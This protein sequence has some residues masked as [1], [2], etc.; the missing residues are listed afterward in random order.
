V[1]V[2]DSPEQT[3]D[4]IN[5]V[6]T[7]RQIDARYATLL[8]GQLSADGKLMFCNAGHNPP[9]VFGGRRPAPHRVGRHAGRHVRD[10]AVL[11]RHHYH[12][13]GDTM[14]LYSDGVTEAQNVA[15]EEFGEARLVQVMERYTRGSAD[16]VLE[17]IID[18][19]KEFA[20]GAEQY[21]DVTALVVK[22]TGPK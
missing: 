10:G 7:R 15:G 14:V 12:E 3:V 20:H 17:Q 8:Y 6:L 13:A 21:D 19:V 16:V 11:V 9:L 5:K 18:S 4:H 2:G 1:S 22:Y